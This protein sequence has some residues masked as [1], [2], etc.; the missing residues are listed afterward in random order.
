MVLR[1]EYVFPENLEIV[2]YI[3]N[4]VFIRY[5]RY[6]LRVT[7][8][9]YVIEFRYS[10]LIYISI[11]LYTYQFCDTVDTDAKDLITTVF[12]FLMLK[13]VF[14]E[15][16]EKRYFLGLVGLAKSCLDNLANISHD[17]FIDRFVRIVFHMILL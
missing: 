11:R 9:V 6:Y 12:F 13:I 14:A 5:R 3:T 15:L 1:L 2:L 16:H 4:A 17:V 10:I 8:Q 7:N